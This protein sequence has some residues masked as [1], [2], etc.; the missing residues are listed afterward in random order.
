MPRIYLQQIKMFT[1]CIIFLNGHNNRIKIIFLTTSDYLFCF[2]SCVMVIITFHIILCRVE[3][4]KIT[5]NVFNFQLFLDNA[6]VVEGGYLLQIRW[7]SILT[8]SVYIFFSVS[9][10]DLKLF[11][12]YELFNYTSLGAAHL[13]L[14]WVS[15]RKYRQDI[16]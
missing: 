13:Y 12:L 4:V 14:S 1:F 15:L 9:G 10:W 16:P 5:K 2:D 8:N 7:T 11:Y 6:F 3:F